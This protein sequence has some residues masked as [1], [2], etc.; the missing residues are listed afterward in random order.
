M[1]IAEKITYET[2]VYTALHNWSM[3]ICLHHIS[4]ACR[5]NSENYNWCNYNN[6]FG[7]FKFG[8]EN[9]LF[10][11]LKLVKKQSTYGNCVCRANFVWDIFGFLTTAMIALTLYTSLIHCHGAGF[12]ESRP[13]PKKLHVIWTL[14]C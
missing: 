11:K 4:C 13:R 12:S 6:C 5:L 7:I 1:Y 9:N 2:T 8:K 3:N 14:G 10:L